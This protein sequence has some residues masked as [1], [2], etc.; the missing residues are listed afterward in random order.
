MGYF[1]LY[2]DLPL[3]TE[4]IFYCPGP[5]VLLI[6]RF[7]WQNIPFCIH[8]W[9]HFVVYT[10]NRTCSS[11]LTF[12]AIKQRNKLLNCIGVIKQPVY[13]SVLALLY[14]FVR[15]HVCMSLWMY[16][17]MYVCIMYVRTYVCIYVLCTYVCLYECMYVRTYVCIYV[18]MC[19]VLMYVSMNVCMY[20]RTYVYMYVRTYVL[21]TYVLL[22]Y[23]YYYLLAACS[24]TIHQ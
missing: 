20:V 22:Y 21:C 15:M 18:Y 5:K 12:P 24:I 7:V 16:V 9:V 6:P 2:L 13:C 11:C 4:A 23:Y 19:Y 10:T 1:I 8:L 3:N 14:W 17:R